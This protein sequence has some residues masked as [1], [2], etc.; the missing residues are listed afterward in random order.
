MKKASRLTAFLLALLFVLSSCSESGTNTDESTSNA[1]TANPSSSESESAETEKPEDT[2]ESIIEKKFADKDYEGQTFTMLGYDAGQHY[3]TN[4]SPIF[5]EI[6]SEGYTGE[7]INDAIYDR[8]AKAEK[9]LNITFEHMFN[10]NIPTMIKQAVTSSSND[11][12]AAL[13]SLSGLGASLQNGE[14][15]N[16]MKFDNID[17]TAEWYDKNCVDTF[18]LFKNKLYWLTGDYM[19]S[20]D[21]A[22]HVIYYNKDIISDN[23]LEQPYTMAYEGTWTMDKFAEMV[24]TCERD[25]DGNGKISINSKEDIVGHIGNGD[26]IKHWVYA[27]REKSIEIDSDGGLTINT[28]NER[29]IN[30]VEKIYKHLVEEE[31]Y[32]TDN[33]SVLIDAFSSK[34]A[35]SYC[36]SLALINLFREMDSDFGILPMPKYDEQQE[37]YGHYISNYVTTAIVCP[38]TVADRDFAGAC[39]EALSAYS[40]DTVSSGLYD[41]LLTSKLVRDNESV[42]MLKICLGTKYFDWAVDFQW[43]STFQSA[44]NGVYTKK[45]FDYVSAAKKATK[46]QEKQINKLLEKIKEFED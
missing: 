7:I 38:K 9:L 39:I 15:A 6:Y 16:L 26:E 25:L 29:Q 23:G 24:S 5:N 12:T 32:Y 17:T 27:G 43:G 31:L 13:A 36:I 33:D 46:L 34:R 4:I 21:Y 37:D 20:D 14:L 8:N 18:T 41:T 3:Y 35:V 11:F 28:L 1:D 45:S 19:L 22:V 44:Y 10:A 42:D 40:T 30:V 2:A